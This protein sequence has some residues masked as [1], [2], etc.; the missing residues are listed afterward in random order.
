MRDNVMFYPAI[1]LMIAEAG[2]LVFLILAWFKAKRE[3]KD[4]E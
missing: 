1:A 4:E 3:R 2:A